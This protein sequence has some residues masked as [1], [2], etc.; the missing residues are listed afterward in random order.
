MTHSL[1]MPPMTFRLRVLSALLLCVGVAVSAS[2]QIAT[3]TWRDHPNFTQCVDV[4]ASSDL[5]LVLV[6]VQTAVFAMT[7][8]EVGVPTGE[9]QRFGKAEGLSRADISTVA[10]SAQSGWAIVAYMEGTFDLI[11]VDP[12]GA[13]SDVVPINDLSEADLLGSKRP[14]RLVL[15]G[16]R[17]MLCTDIGVVEYDLDGLE[18]RDTWKLESD[19]V[20]LAVRSVARVA[21][22]WWA[23]TSSGL[24]VAP[25]GATFP[26]NPATWTLAGMAGADLLDLLPLESGGL[27]TIER[28]EGADAVWWKPVTGDWTDVSLGLNEDWRRLASDGDHF[29][30][31]TAFGLVQWEPNGA[32]SPIQTQAGSV[33]LQPMG[34][35]GA[36]EGLWLANAHSG[37][38]RLDAGGDAFHG[39]FAPNGPRSNA[40]TRLDA[41]NEWL[42]VASGGTDAAGVP[43]YRQAGFSGRKGTWWRNIAPPEGEA[44]GAGVQDPVEVSIHPLDPEVAVF[45]SLEEGLI[46]V[47]GAGIRNFWNPSNSPLEWNSTWDVNRCTVSA[48][49]FDRQ[50]NLWVANEGTE[51]PLKMRDAEGGWHAF[52]LEGLGP[53]TGFTRLLA[54]QGDQVWMALAK[55]GGVAVMSTAGTPEDPSDDDFRILTQAEGEGGLP[56]SFVYALEEDLDGEIWVGTL[57]GPAV[58]YQPSSLFG[59][60]TTDAQQILIEQDG[61]FQFLLE[62]ET[63]WDIALDGGNRKWVAT[64]NNGAFLLTPDG[65]GQVAHFTAENSPLPTDEVYDVAIDQSSGLVYFATPNGIT[66]FRGTATNFVSELGQSPLAIFPNPLRPEDPPRVT[67]DG[68]A[69]GSEVHIVD[70]AGRNVRRLD[71]AGGRVFWD[72]LDEEG[73]PVPEGV[74]FALAGEAGSKSGGSGKMLILR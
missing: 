13:L 42:W 59:S 24:W 7:L 35:S 64:V 47:E 37:V 56:S 50:G 54:T 12:D 38:L 34:I 63:V 3:G 46:E 15:D 65:R 14:H 49:D 45:G 61:N 43:L 58:F 2:A 18:V 6:A 55:G 28:R 4:A 19:G 5:G 74:Y 22:Q 62:T 57:Q 51:H 36:S 69:F 73:R 53:A 39:P 66:S 60:E 1:P 67:I 41:W 9:I 17:L 8:D 30:A 40:C 20:P 33:Y 21:G 44:G 27:V 11:R 32:P 25:V 10:L 72:T 29:W 16:D 23:A 48:L 71:S 26:G 31:S 68:L 70:A 52:E